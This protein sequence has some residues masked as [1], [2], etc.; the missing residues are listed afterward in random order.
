MKGEGI[1]MVI[2]AYEVG[3]VILLGLGIKA[4]NLHF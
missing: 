4:T 1:Y 2:T 3:G